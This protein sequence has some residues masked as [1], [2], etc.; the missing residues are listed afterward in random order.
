MQRPLLLQPTNQV[1]L[2]VYDAARGHEVSPVGAS[3]PRVPD[4]SA[5]PG[6]EIWQRLLG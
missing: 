1:G 3:R 4:P 2:P 6:R 5:G